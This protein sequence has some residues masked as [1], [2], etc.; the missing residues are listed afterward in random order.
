MCCQQEVADW[1]I[2]E[3]VR[4]IPYCK[5]VVERFGHF[6]V[7][8]VDIAVVH[9]V[10]CKFFVRSTFTLCNFVFVVWE[11]KVLTAAV[12]VNCFTQMFAAHCRTF[13]M[14]ARTA[15][16]EWACPV[17]FTRFC[18]FPQG[19]VC[20]G[21]L[22]FANFNS[23]ACFQFF[24]WLMAQFAI[25][26]ERVY[27]EVNVAVFNSICVSF[28]NKSLNNI[29]DF[30][31]MVR[32]SW[33]HICKANI[34]TLQVVIVFVFIF[35]CNS[36]KSNAFFNGT[37]DDFVINVCNVGNIFY[38]VAF[39]FKVTAQCVKNNCRAGIA[40]VD[41][42]VNCRAANVDFVFTFYQW[43]KL[44]FFAGKCVVNI[45]MFHKKVLSGLKPFKIL[46]QRPN[47]TKTAP[48]CHAAN[49]GGINNHGS[50]SIY[51]L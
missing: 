23:C 2:T 6:L 18:S 7:V 44:F 48:I 42:V 17:W 46:N 3:L 47:I 25:V 14:P 29:N 51:I 11:D 33:T 9:P 1:F 36:F 50:T 22:D 5:E 15:F 24:Q 31:N 40:D 30:R 32:N 35:S 45:H 4:N 39:V 49:E 41:I 8:N 37:F 12:Q 13:N 38:L 21:F 20:S 16:A 43:N 27:T 10:T 34:Q 28:V 19:K 26:L